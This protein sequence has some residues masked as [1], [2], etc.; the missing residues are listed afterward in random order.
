M[1]S[2]IA[3]YWRTPGRRRRAVREAAWNLLRSRLRFAARGYPEI[4]EDFGSPVPVGPRD[5]LP[6][7]HP[8]SGL[9]GWAV[10][11]VAKRMP[12]E[13]DCIVRAHAAMRMLA[14]RGIRTRT[15]VGAYRGEEG[16]IELHAMLMDG[17]RV[18]TG[19]ENQASFRR[20]A[21]YEPRG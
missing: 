5:A 18:V 9:V 12:F 7:P 17:T 3:A 8:D 14:R 13:C 6:P 10:E 1:R 16:G 4:M 20:L 19:M 21:S 15:V 2:K 11:A